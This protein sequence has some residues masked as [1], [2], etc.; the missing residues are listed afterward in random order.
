M[1]YVNG[2]VRRQDRLLD[3]ARALELVRTCEYGVLSMVTAGGEAYGLPLNYVWDGHGSL[4]VHCAPEGR[5]LEAIACNPSVSFCIVGRTNLLPSR[6]TT[7]YE[8]VVMKCRAVIGLSDDEKR[9]VYDQ[10]GHDGLNGQFGSGGFTWDNFTRFDDI[11]D[12][13]GGD[14]FSSFFGGGG[15]Q[16]RSGPAQ[17]NSLRYDLEID[18]IDVLNGKEVELSIPHHAK[19]PDCKGTGGKDGN[20]TTCSR[21]GGRGQVQTVRNTPFGQ[22]V[23]VADCPQCHGRGKSFTERCPKCGGRAVIQKTSKIQVRIPKGIESGTRIRVPGA[24]D[25][26]PDGGPNGDLF[27]VV[28]VREQDAF[29]RDGINLWT[30]LTASY[31][32]LVL[33]G[34]MQV[35]TLEGDKILLKIPAGTQVGSVLRIPGKGLPKGNSSS[36]GDLFVRMRVDVPKKVTE[37]QRE[38]LKKLDSTAGASTSKRKSSM[39]DKIREKLDI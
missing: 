36:R 11:S 3:E 21:C 8:S 33:G 14:F 1:K 9:R 15:R 6:F 2:T 38:L 4:Y 27:V 16:S 28:Y 24:G 31:P 13:F 18:L 19:C 23:S 7:E 32:K 25:A 10:Y 35:Q 29:E 5:K 22:M 34:E 12:I 30:G 17:G 26:S 39:K 37:E 20:V